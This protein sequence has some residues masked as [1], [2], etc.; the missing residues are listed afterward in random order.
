M[1]GRIENHCSFG[2]E[3]FYQVLYTH[4]NVTVINAWVCPEPLKPDSDR[5]GK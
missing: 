5:P 2:L 3:V 1:H 4:T